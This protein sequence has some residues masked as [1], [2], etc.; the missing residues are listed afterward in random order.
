M[1]PWIATALFVSI[2]LIGTATWIRF[3]NQTK[4]SVGLI[5]VNNA[6]LS[7][8][9]EPTISGPNFLANQDLS[10]TGTSTD[11]NLSG[12]DMIGRQMIIDYVNLAT[13]GQASDESIN[14]LANQYV[15]KIPNLSSASVASYL[16]IKTVPNE[17]VN[18]QNYNDSLTKIQKDYSAVLNSIPVE[19]TNASTP[20]PKFYSAIKSISTAY[21]ETV[22][23]LKMLPTP[24]ALVQ[25]HLKLINNYLSSASAMKAVS[26][27]EKDPAFAFAGLVTIGN[28]LKETNLII[29]EIN[30][31]LAKNGI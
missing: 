24:I 16:D 21:S 12:T 3:Q 17:K 26:E 22:T 25:V 11:E 10:N 2:L 14:A 20:G 7:S 30:Q 5:A 6:G 19:I 18:F 1:K 27:T 31:I 8:S 29:G 15:E 13:S 28:N 23:K 9:T 4:T